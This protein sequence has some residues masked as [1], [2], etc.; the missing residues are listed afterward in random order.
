MMH[1]ISKF[2]IQVDVLLVWESLGKPP[3]KFSDGLAK[4]NYYS[5]IATDVL[6][7]LWWDFSAIYIHV[8]LNRKTNMFRTGI[9]VGL[10]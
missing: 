5:K 1:S 7:I 2:P 4:L 9:V 3:L 8:E 10:C 6:A